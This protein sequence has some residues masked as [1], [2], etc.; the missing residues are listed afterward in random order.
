MSFAALKQKISQ[1]QGF[2][3]VELLVVMVLIGILASLIA[4]SFVGAT[5]KARDS[6]RKADIGQLQRALEAYY[7][8][9]GVYPSSSNT[10][11][12]NIMVGGSALGWGSAFQD[13]NST[14]YMAQLPNDAKQPTIQ[15]FYV[16][17][18]DHKAYQI[19]IH[20]ENTLDPQLLSSTPPSAG[21]VC[22]T[23]A[24]NY[25]VSSSNIKVTDAL[26]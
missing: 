26:P 14:L 22:G 11:S 21:N 24:C 4:G 25:G 9:Y 5:I 1:T 20:L 17:R 8:D 19:F 2:T 6:K 15:Y 3:L 12:S 16:S 13:A 10:V 23:S 7:N 18:A